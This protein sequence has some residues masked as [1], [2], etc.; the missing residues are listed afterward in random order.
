LQQFFDRLAEAA[1]ALGN[2]A[3]AA[4]QQTGEIPLAIGGE[5]GRAVFGYTVRMGLEGLRAE[6][7]G[8]KPPAPH[9]HAA[10][11][12]GPAARAPIVDLFEEGEEIR[13]VAELP[14]V[15]DEEIACTLH[16]DSLQI[17]TVGAQIYSKTL[18]L[19][20]AVDPASLSRGC[21]NGIL[22]V[23]LRRALG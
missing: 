18:K 11:S 9:R 4:V 12:P 22:E 13:I 2:D 16:G 1:E 3:S 7:F 20:H 19:P 6:A 21:R 14:G 17:Q 15:A 5:K 8:D 23:R 10:G